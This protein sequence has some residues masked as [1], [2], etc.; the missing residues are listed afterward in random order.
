M[1]IVIIY[2]T[3]PEAIKLG[4]VVAELKALGITPQIISTGQHWDLLRGTPAETDLKDSWSL[5]LP[6]NGDPLTWVEHAVPLIGGALLMLEPS[7]PPWTVVVQGDTA[8]ALA[9]ARAAAEWQFPLVHIEA[10]IRSGNLQEP[11]PEEGFRREITELATWHYAPTSHCVDNLLAEGIPQ[12]R[13]VMTGNPVVSALQRYADAKPRKPENH[14]LLTM[15]RR[16]WL[17]DVD[18]SIFLAQINDACIQHP[19]VGILWP[20]H[21]VVGNRWP[22]HFPSDECPNFR[23]THP[24]DYQMMIRLLSEATGLLTD[25][26]G[27]VEEACT[28][29]IPTAIMRNSN[30]RPEAIE[31]GVARQFAPDD[32]ESAFD[33]LVAQ[34]RGPPQSTFGVP[35][36]AQYIAQHLE[37]LVG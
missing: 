22:T 32:L 33:W 6:A 12:D 1:S 36:S 25:S 20:V 5:N 10:G 37:T 31:A 24:L 26:G 21:P 14:I 34:K 18:L 7:I 4:P 13:I 27:L 35:A 3:R 15:H 23:V 8:S 29:G 9:G 30:D 17:R 11:W 2:G 19:S 28:L 16:E